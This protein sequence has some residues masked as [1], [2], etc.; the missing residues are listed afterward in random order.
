MCPVPQHS[1]TV[2]ITCALGAV[3]FSGGVGVPGA[4]GSDKP[5]VW[6]LT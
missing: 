3:F 5:G 1:T 2:F 6:I 4:T